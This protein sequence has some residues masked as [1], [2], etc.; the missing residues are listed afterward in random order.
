MTNSEL[1]KMVNRHIDVL[2]NQTNLLTRGG[3]LDAL[4]NKLESIQN[5]TAALLL[6]I[7]KINKERN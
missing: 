6:M 2:N 4:K 1:T 5:E 7:P 3:C